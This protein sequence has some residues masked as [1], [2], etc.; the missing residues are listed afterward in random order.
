MTDI[1]DAGPRLQAMNDALEENAR[2]REAIRRLGEQDATLS[3]LCKR[4]GSQVV[5][6]TLDATLT[7]AEREAIDAAA[8]AAAQLYV[9]PDGVALA[10]TL[11]GLLERT[12]T[13]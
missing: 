12:K 8:H 1:T 7:D 2:L 10:A 5:T 4:D 11:R 9:G 3:L 6:V 13:V